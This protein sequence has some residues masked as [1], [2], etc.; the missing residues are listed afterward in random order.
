M[1]GDSFWLPVHKRKKQYIFYVCTYI[2][3]DSNIF[4]SHFYMYILYY[5]MNGFFFYEEGNNFFLLRWDL[6]NVLKILQ[7]TLSILQNFRY[8]FIKYTLFHFLFVTQFHSC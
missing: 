3:R 4:F 8:K 5:R 1:R 7:H 6:Y 2:L